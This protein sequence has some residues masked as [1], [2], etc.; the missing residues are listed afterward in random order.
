MAKNRRFHNPP[1]KVE[2]KPVVE[3]EEVKEEPMV[4]VTEDNIV[5]AI[6]DGVQM[7]LNIRMKPVVEP[8][9]QIAIVGKGSKL[10]VIDPD[11][12]YDGSDEKWYKVKVPKGE[13]GYAMKKY[14]KLI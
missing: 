8:N 9:N 5:D 11:K 4:E 1:T 12:T 2:P 13:T 6:V 3:T 14:I 7:S 10:K